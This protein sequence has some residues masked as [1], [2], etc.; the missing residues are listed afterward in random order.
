MKNLILFI[1]IIIITI[2]CKKESG[3]CNCERTIQ[4][5]D[6]NTSY[7]P[8]ILSDEYDKSASKKCNNLENEFQ[9]EQNVFVSSNDNISSSLINCKIIN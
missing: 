3:S 9:T 4:Y 7:Q 6:G 8:S 5:E 1:L 2:S